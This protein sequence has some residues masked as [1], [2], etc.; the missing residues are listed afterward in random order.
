MPIDKID[1][2]STRNLIAAV[3]MEGCYSK[4]L[5]I[6]AVFEIVLCEVPRLFF[7]KKCK[8][9]K[10]KGSRSP[11]IYYFSSCPYQNVRVT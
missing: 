2:F 10:R 9:K 6:A 11:H 1:F 7:G 5:Q 8:S 4:E 3:N